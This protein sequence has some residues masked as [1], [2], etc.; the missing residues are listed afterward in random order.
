MSVPSEAMCTCPVACNC[1][2]P[3]AA[4]VSNSC[5]VHNHAPR[6]DPGCQSENIVHRNGAVD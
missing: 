4:P 2:N 5:P 6:P 1:E 3:E